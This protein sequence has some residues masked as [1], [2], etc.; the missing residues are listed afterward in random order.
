MLDIAVTKQDTNHHI[1]HIKSSIHE[2]YLESNRKTVG[3]ITLVLSHE[4]QKTTDVALG[5]FKMIGQV[6]IKN[7][8]H[9]IQ[10]EHLTDI[11][12]PNEKKIEK[13]SNKRI[14]FDS[15]TNKHFITIEIS[16]EYS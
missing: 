12:S 13:I 4:E 15:V 6:W 9:H 5:T 10:V 8:N 14:N 2:M 1:H 16:D 7:T 11:H 3:E